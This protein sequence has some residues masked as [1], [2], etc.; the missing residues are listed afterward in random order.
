MPLEDIFKEIEKEF[1]PF[2]EKFYQ[3]RYQDGNNYDAPNVLEELNSIPDT[4]SRLA[5]TKKEKLPNISN[6]KR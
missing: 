2:L 4:P 6:G 1:I 5:F 3:L